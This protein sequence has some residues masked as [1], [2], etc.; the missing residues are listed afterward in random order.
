M[1]G[2]NEVLRLLTEPGDAVVVNCPVYPPFYAFVRN[3]GRRVVEAP[4]TAEGRIDLA[5][6][7]TAFG[8]ARRGGEE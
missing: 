4:L 7:A 8:E 2:I 3:L 1:L 5:T 6:L